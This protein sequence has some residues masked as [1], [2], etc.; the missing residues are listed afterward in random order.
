MA[1]DAAGEVGAG[2]ACC[3]VWKE[4][5]A[6]LENKRNALRHAVNILQ[7]QIDRFQADNAKLRKAYEEEQARADNEKE[8][9]LK[10][11]IARVSLENEITTLKSE[12]SSLRQKE[13]TNALDRNEGEK[14]IK[15]LKELLEKEKRRAD[16]ERKSAEGEKKKAAE[17]LKS[18]KAE[19]SKADEQRS[20]AKIEREK[21]EQYRLQLE[22]LKKEADEAK[23]KLAA[24][25]LKFEQANKKLEAEKRKAIQERK[26]AESEMAK[27]EEQRK[28]AEANGKKA[29][30][31]KRRAE[32]LSRQLEE[33]RQ[34]AEE[35][36]K[37][38][39][40][41]VSSG[42]SAY[43]HG[44][45]VDNKSNP[46]YE[47]MKDRI[48]SKILNVKGDEP[49]LVLELL[50]ESKKRFEIE[51][52]KVIRE[53]KHAD[54]EMEKVEEQKR[55]VEVNWKKAME[56]KC[57]ADQLSQQLQEDKRTIEELQ[58]K[59]HELQS[60]RKLVEGSA[61]SH[62]R[63]I[64]SEDSNV[65]L[66]KKQLKLEKLQVKH[67]K[68]VAKFEKS[69]YRNL[70]Q[71][72]G[73]LKLEFDKFANHLDILNNSFSPSA[74]GIDDLEKTGH[75]ACMQRLNMKKQLCSMEPSQAHFQ[76]ENELQM[77][78]CIDMDSSD[79]CGQTLQPSAPLLSLSG[80]NFAE[81]ISGINSTLESPLGYSNR[82]LLQ[83][84]TINSST[85]SFSD[86]QLMGSQERGAFSVTTSA[87][88]VEENLN[89]QPTIS[90]LSGEVTK[91]R[92]NEKFAK[93]AENNVKIP[94]SNDVGRVCE[95]IKKR[96]RVLDSVESI[97]YLYSKGKKLNTQIE[98]KLS[99]LHGMLGRQVGNQLGEGRCLAPNL[100]CIPY[101]MLD[102][103]RKSW[104]SHDEVLEK[105]FCES[106]GRKK[107]EKVETEVLKDAIDLG[108]LVSFEDVA[109]GDHMKLLALD[110]AADEESYRVALEV[111]LS[112]SL[113]NIDFHGVESFDVDNSEALVV[114]CAYEG[115]S[116]NKENLVGMSNL[117]ISRHEELKFPV[118]S[119]LGPSHD[120]IPKYCVVFPDMRD[121]NTVYRIF[122]AA[123][124]CIA[125]CSLLSQT[126]WV[127]PK[128]LLALK[129]EENLLLVEKV[130]V[131]FTLLLL[132][133]STAAP[134]KFGS[135]LNK[136]SILCMDSFARHIQAVMSDV[137]TRSIF[138]DFGCVDELLS[139][140]EDFLIFGRVIVYD[141]VSSETFI[142]CD[143]RIDFLLDGVNI[144]LLYVAAS[145]DV[146]VAGSIILAS[147]CASIDHIGFIC[148]TSYNI[149]LRRACDSS[150]V[151]TILHVFAYLGGQKF[152]SLSNYKL[153]MMVLKSI[154]MLLEGVNLSVDAASCPSSVSKVQLQFH[155][156]VK[157]PFS[158]GAISV[159]TLTLL[160]LELLQNIAVFGTTNH[161]VIKSFNALNSGVLCDN[162]KSEQYS[163][164]EEVLCVADLNCEVSCGL[165]K[166]E[167]PTTKSDS[168]VKWTL[169]HLSDVL[170]LVELIACNMSWDWTSVKMVPQ[171]LKVLESC[172][173][174]NFAA[175]IVVLLGQLGM[176]GVDAGGYEDTGVEN[177]RCNLSAFLS[178]DATMKAGL[179][180]Q[181]ATVTAL[182]GLLPL[183]FETLLQS[184]VKLQATAS[185]SVLVD[186]IRKWFSLLSKEQQELSVS[187]LQTAGVKEK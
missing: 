140:I 63:V 109:D 27:V 155:P 79:T 76:R 111:P 86:G 172:V 2:N 48:Q 104:K 24:E 53:K 127:V 89:T 61:V 129:M 156:C 119:E 11:S 81:S 35:L 95:H 5:Y 37:E 71:E 112:P 75:I 3:K 69:R 33:N 98:E 135:V 85:A 153:M 152:F 176:L 174:E 151:L 107:T 45:Q 8:G 91:I 181:I 28:L 105:H 158:E 177:L 123:K 41:F 118:E 137:E 4:K 90:N 163:S 100:Q 44:G 17:E 184:N 82:K 133:F 10:E 74:E 168:A 97:E 66:L 80:G 59:I 121:R 131:F 39:L 19:K 171:L 126:E 32:N 169:C 30:E 1:A 180:I 96:K 87:K 122:C 167:M 12:I 148:E 142:E 73:C 120:D 23:S 62:R 145:A 49:K 124:T 128:I 136:D 67:A 70:Q 43:S 160:L 141:N 15:R 114:E 47:K 9:R 175:A 99:V 13:N 94:D 117:P 92:F 78:S 185:Q 157:C 108:T 134:R 21:A 60:F 144:V 40:E 83:T 187:L 51:K 139:L 130:C 166:C 25:T 56:E 186:F 34:S 55:H 132:N 26:R 110:N 46:E 161:D 162:F 138:A 18:I 106:D 29:L 50:K 170:S 65:K 14:E 16:A 68:Q 72:L 6:N 150:L 146:L 57:R 183:D 164:H 64:H 165:D 93:V 149:F 178:R 22:I 147:I 102:G 7:P 173:L 36:Q 116:T 113:P 54:I 77:P 31:E 154:V 42:N 101:P 84:S 103:F 115:L 179:P 52:Q 125:R 58:K 182:L 143:S 38:I 159:D 88:L 20:T